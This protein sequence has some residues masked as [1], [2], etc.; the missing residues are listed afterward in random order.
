MQHVP[1]LSMCSYKLK[2]LSISRASLTCCLVRN[3]HKVTIATRVRATNFYQLQTIHCNDALYYSRWL[4]T[5]ERRKTNTYKCNFKLFDSKQISCDMIRIY[6][7]VI[8]C[9]S[10]KALNL[11][12]RLYIKMSIHI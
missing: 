8:L 9:V 1:A 4:A 3:T 2:F 7:T 12:S 10:Y 11:R 5:R 6:L